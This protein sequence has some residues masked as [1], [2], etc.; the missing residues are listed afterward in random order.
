M[1]KARPGSVTSNSCPARGP[2]V[3]QIVKTGNPLISK[4]GGLIL[5]ASATPMFNGA[6]TEW[7]PALGVSWQ[8]PQKPEMLGWLSASI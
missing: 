3:H 6:L 5:P 4:A 2:D 8:V 7:F 1:I